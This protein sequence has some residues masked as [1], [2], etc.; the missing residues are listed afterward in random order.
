M[1]N[2]IWMF[3]GQGSQRYQMMS[4]LYR[5]NVAFR[6]AMERCNEIVA[7]LLGYSMLEVIYGPRDNPTALFDR[8]LDTHPAL[9]SVQYACAE[10]MFAQG[11]R[12]DLLLCYSLGEYVGWTV[13]GALDLE[14]ALCAVVTQAK[15]LEARVP[16]GAML[17]V[18]DNP[19]SVQP[20]ADLG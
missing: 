14:A 1:T 18:L 19:R 5:D 11:A 10:M 12:P 8:T 13:S 9:F 4:R 3:S 20:P 2:N 17:A 7:P 15:L 16:K 6:S